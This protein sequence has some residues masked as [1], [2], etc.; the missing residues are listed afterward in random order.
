MAKKAK[1]K[2]SKPTPAGG[3][4]KGARGVRLVHQLVMATVIVE[5]T[6]KDGSISTGTGFIVDDGTAAVTAYHVIRDALKV[7]LIR[8]PIEAE[9]TGWTKGAYIVGVRH[10]VPDPEVSEGGILTQ[11]LGE[12]MESLWDID[13]SIMRICEKFE[14]A[15]PLQFDSEP[16]LM[17]EE[18]LFTG[19][20][21]G[22]LNFETNISS[23]YPVP[24]ATKA[25][26]AG[27]IKFAT[28]ID[29]GKLNEYYYWLDRPS[30]PGNS[31]GP[32]MRVKTG[33]IVG[34]ISATPF[35]PKTIRIG[36]DMVNSYIPDGYSIAYGTSN[37]PRAIATTP[38][39]QSTL[40][41]LKSV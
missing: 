32:V 26:V 13:I 38:R 24:L 29:N 4:D 14:G 11:D 27:A 28:D 16:A 3:F 41:K 9:V 22:G 8:H 35:M 18:I 25:I 37:L 7:K 34:V 5:C 10:G 36:T 39:K 21:G 30:F 23:C 19:Y 20:P 12:G 33:K 17:G 31:G 2:S 15:I 1:V 40:L 6:K